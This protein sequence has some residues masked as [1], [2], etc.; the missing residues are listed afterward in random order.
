M[1]TPMVHLD[2]GAAWPHPEYVAELEWRL[3]YGE[4]ERGAAL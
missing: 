3:R 1:T 4:P 2:G